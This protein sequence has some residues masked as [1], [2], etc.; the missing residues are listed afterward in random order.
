MRRS[1]LKSVMAAGLVLTLSPLTGEA[2][3]QNGFSLQKIPTSYTIGGKTFTNVEGYILDITDY[4]NVN[5]EVP[6]LESYYVRC[7]SMHPDGFSQERSNCFA[8]T[9]Y[10]CAS[11]YQ[12]SSNRPARYADLVPML[13][14]T[15]WA[16]RYHVDN[17]GKDVVAFNLGFF[18]TD[19]FPGRSTNQNLWKPIYQEACM[20]NLGTLRPDD[21]NAN[22]VSR[23][24]DRE[25]TNGQTDR[26]F[27]TLRF[28]SG[29]SGGLG[30]RLNT[31]MDSVIVAGDIAING[32]WI[33]Y[34]GSDT[35]TNT[36]PQFVIDKQ[37]SA[38]GRTAIGIDPATDRMRV[39]V[40][41]P[42]RGA[43]N[44]GAS[45]G[46][47][48]RFFNASTFPNVMLLD[49]SGSSQMASN[50]R[51]STSLG[52][53]VTQPRTSCQFVGVQECTLHGDSVEKAFVSHYNDIFHPQDPNN[54]SNYLVDRRVPNV[55]VIWEK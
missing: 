25:V 13:P 43:G 40:I 23:Y 49:G 22:F 3:A 28:K 5:I 34:N 12:N 29:G 54:A 7:D 8:G 50:F 15:N 16:S 33:R 38:V 17:P 1:I 37:N 6:N 19:P 52:S 26:P 32:V 24:T 11:L 48:K 14:A 45:I 4:Q 53:V 2:H 27:G 10:T 47:M 9:N 39:V 51:A 42:S 31:D 20:T 44:A 18:E 36:W 30:R 41:Q 46:D 21:D 55:M 35:S